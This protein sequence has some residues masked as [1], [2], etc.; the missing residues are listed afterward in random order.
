MRTLKNEKIVFAGLTG[1]IGYPLALRLA[2]DNEVWGIA[3]SG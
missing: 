2:T 3:A 1:Q